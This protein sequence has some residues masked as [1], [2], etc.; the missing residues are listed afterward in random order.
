MAGKDS[1]KASK[2]TVK[3]SA[4]T[5]SAKSKKTVVRKKPAA[6]SHFVARSKN[7]GIGH[8]VPYARDL[9]RFMR[10]PTFVTMQRKKRVL[11]RRLKVPPALNQFTKVLDR[12]SRN[13][14]LKLIKKY[15]PETRKARRARLSKVAA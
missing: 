11:Q 10:W 8:D 3:K 7:F 14:A 13:E 2:P 4:A 1:K 12:T 9:S 5:V 6:V 15:A